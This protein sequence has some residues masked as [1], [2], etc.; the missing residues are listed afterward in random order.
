M[1][2]KIHYGNRVHQSHPICLNKNR[3]NSLDNQH[4]SKQKAPNVNQFY[5]VISLNIR[6]IRMQK[7]HCIDK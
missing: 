3:I 1:L 6:K 2:L 4:Y 7:I 5:N